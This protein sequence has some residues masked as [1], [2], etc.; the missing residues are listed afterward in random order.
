MVNGVMDFAVALTTAQYVRFF[1]SRS[2][3][4]SL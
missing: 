4:Y 1:S 2:V 3:D